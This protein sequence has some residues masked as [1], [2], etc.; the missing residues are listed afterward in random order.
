MNIL[1]REGHEIYS[2]HVN[3]VLSAFDSKR[4]IADDGIHTNAYGYNKPLFT[5]AEI[6]FMH[7]NKISLSAFDSRT[8]SIQMLTSR[9]VL[10]LQ[11]QK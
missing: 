5:D 3:K 6:E 2:V 1:R 11:M 9:L 8:G 7:V 4:W 10:Y